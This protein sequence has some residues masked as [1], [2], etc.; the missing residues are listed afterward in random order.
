M[1]KKMKKFVMLIAVAVTLIGGITLWWNNGT[2]AANSSDRKTRSFTVNKGEGLRSI[3]AHL[4]EE[5]LIR[6]KI[7]FYALIKQNGLDG[8]IQAGE[9]QLSPSLTPNEIAQ[10]MT[11]GSLD[12]WVTIPEGKRAAEIAEILASKLST[13]DS[14]WKPKLIENEGYLFPDTYLI[15][16]DASL[17]QVLTILKDNF[18]KKYQEASQN[19]TASLSKEDGVILASILEREGRS[20][21]DKKM[22]ASVLENRLNIGMALQTDATIQYVVGGPMNWWPTPTA[23]NLKIN[24]PYNTYLNPGLPPTP[25]S[26]PGLDALTAAFHPADTNY[27]YYIS[28]SKGMLHFAR[29]LDEQNTNIRKFGL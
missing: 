24:S 9:Y 19:A 21:E 4:Q 7:V 12:I 16:H 6:D 3:A 26:N 2:S 10:L 23:Q 22:I 11:K 1:T 14:T 13:V 18:E 15:P 25:I 5:G 29:T 8:K 17:E 28:D 27:F 20:V